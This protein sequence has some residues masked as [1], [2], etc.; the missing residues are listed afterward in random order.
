MD[1]STSSQDPVTDTPPEGITTL[2]L[3]LQ[4]D[5][6]E[7]LDGIKEQTG[8]SLNTLINKAIEHAM[9]PP[10]GAA[11][12]AKARRKITPAGDR[13]QQAWEAVAFILSYLG[14]KTDAQ[15][16][17]PWEDPFPGTGEIGDLATAGGLCAA[18]IDL[19]QNGTQGSVD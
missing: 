2:T 10:G 5:L 4:P 9:T 12:I 6:K 8:H 17:W 19:F 11:Q 18:E 16:A 14:A 13:A 15:R 3:R 7:Y 1:V